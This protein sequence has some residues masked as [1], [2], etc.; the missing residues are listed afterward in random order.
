MAGCRLAG[1]VRRAAGPALLAA[2]AL[3]AGCETAYYSTL[4]QFGVEKRDVLVDRVTDARDAQEAAKEQFESALEQFVAATGFDGGALEARYRT[5]KDAYESSEDRAGTVRKRIARVEDVAGDL[6]AEWEAELSE[7]SR[8]S[9][10]AASRQQLEDTRE[11]YRTLIA[12]MRAAE[13]RIDPVLAAF[14]DQV[15]FL[16]HNLN[17]R[18]IDSLRSDLA[19]VESDIA[20]LVAEMNASIAEANAFIDAMAPRQ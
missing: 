15:L 2:A 11:R 9:L 4:E 8:E 13:A 19:S 3:V 6:F 16:K 12:A 20:T 10:R 17:A 7:Y 5:L 1:I 18:A 14:R